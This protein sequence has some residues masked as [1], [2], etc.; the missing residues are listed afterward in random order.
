MDTLA[1]RKLKQLSEIDPATAAAVT[2]LHL[3]IMFNDRYQ[4]NLKKSRQYCQ[5]F[6]GQ[7][8]TKC[9]IGY[10]IKELKT[11]IANMK[12]AQ[13]KCKNNKCKEK[14][15]SKI[16]KKALQIKELQSQLNIVIKQSYG[17]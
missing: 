13:L 5:H 10:K 11:F 7:E 6:E 16:D 15:E 4:S 9:L 8:K 2:A 17:K 1:V 3:V 12:K 14:I